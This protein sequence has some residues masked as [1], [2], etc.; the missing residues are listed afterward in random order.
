MNKTKINLIWAKLSQTTEK[1]KVLCVVTTLRGI[2][3]QPEIGLLLQEQ[4]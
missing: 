3:N 1:M 2:L 4:D